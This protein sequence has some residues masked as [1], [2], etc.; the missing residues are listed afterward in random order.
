VPGGTGSGPL[1][2]TLL[3][4][5]SRFFQLESGPRG[6]GNRYLYPRKDCASSICSSPVVPHLQGTNEGPDGGGHDCPNNPSLAISALVSS[7][8]DHGIHGVLIASL[9]ARCISNV[10]FFGR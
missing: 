9:F 7:V 5:A 4:S 1:R 8:T 6:H 3:N 10:E 2:H